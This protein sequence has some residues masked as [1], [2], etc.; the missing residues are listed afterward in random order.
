MKNQKGITLIALVITIIVLIILAAVSIAMLTGDSGILTNTDNAREDTKSSSYADKI[1][2]E[3][4]AFK[5]DLLGEPDH[6]ITYDTFKKAVSSLGTTDYTF[7]IGSTEVNE[8]SLNESTVASGET[9]SNGEKYYNGLINP[10]SGT[11]PTDVTITSTKDSTV[12]GSISL[13]GRYPI[14]QATYTKASEKTNP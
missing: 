9:L 6:I 13:T 11:K 1:N 8:E 4:N 12:T 14:T 2:M 7:E 3:L 10:A 5:A